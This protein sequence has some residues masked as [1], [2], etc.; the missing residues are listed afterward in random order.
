MSFTDLRR[1]RQSKSYIKAAKTLPSGTIVDTAG[2]ILAEHDGIEQFTIGQRKGL[3]FAAG[4][5]R[6]VLEIVPARNEV[7][8]GDREELLASGLL[9][10]RCNWFRN[11]RE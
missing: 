4:A 9:A 3:G 11:A 10:S 6:Y 7:V 8:V 1:A 5:R 2:K